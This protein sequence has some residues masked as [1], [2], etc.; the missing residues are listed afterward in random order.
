MTKID[1][2][3]DWIRVIFSDQRK[4]IGC[5]YWNGPCSFS[6]CPMPCNRYPLT[7]VYCEKPLGKRCAIV[8][9]FMVHRGRCAERFAES[10]DEARV[11]LE[12]WRRCMAEIDELKGRE[13]DEAI[14]VAM[15]WEKGAVY[16]YR[17]TAP[18][19]VHGVGFTHS[20]G[21]SNLDDF[22]PTLDHLSSVKRGIERW[23][24][25]W[26]C[27]YVASKRKFRFTVVVLPVERG[28]NNMFKAW[29]LT[30]ETAG[31][32]AFLKACEAVKTKE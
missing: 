10:F 28:V 7:C 3:K 8:R 5:Q 21:D 17:L 23:G 16:W 20:G 15:G 13:L 31:C 2:L 30:E 4:C 26:Y 19:A 9:G 22:C 18:S 1:R 12:E 29:A 27:V 25:N 32:R 11:A 24:W 6:V 14:A